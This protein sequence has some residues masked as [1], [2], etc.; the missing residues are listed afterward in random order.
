MCWLREWKSNQQPPTQVKGHVEINRSEPDPNLN[1]SV[2]IP[3]RCIICP[4]TPDTMVIVTRS[5]RVYYRY[6]YSTLCYMCRV[7]TLRCSPGHHPHHVVPP[8]FEKRCFNIKIPHFTISISVG[9]CQLYW[10]INF[11][12]KLFTFTK[13]FMKQTHSPAQI[14]LNYK[15]CTSPVL[16]VASRVWVDH[17]LLGDFVSLTIRNRYPRCQWTNS[18]CPSKA[19]H[20]PRSSGWYR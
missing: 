11:V 2:N 12:V 18:F 1:S 6:T 20:G 5:V 10:T 14:W 16:T 19:K 7:K 17:Y 9:A 8:L 4:L 13:C 3:P 15:Y